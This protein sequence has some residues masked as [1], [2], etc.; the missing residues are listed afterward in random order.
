MTV[1]DI[2]ET[3]KQKVKVVFDDQLTLVLYKGELK[4]Y[5]LKKGA[6]VPEDLPRRIEKEVL[7]KRATK[8]AMNLLVKRD[9]TAKELT[10][11]LLR[12]GYSETAGREALRYVSSYGYV[13]DEDYARRYLE[14]YSDRKTFKVMQLELLRKGIPE[15]IISRARE[16]A[17]TADE[18][19]LLRKL[20]EKKAAALNLSEDKDCQKLLRF[21]LG[22][23]FS[24]SQA[25]EALTELQAENKMKTD[26]W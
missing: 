13:R 2:I 7:Y 5:C 10:D 16:A 9:Y 18:Q 20:A 3:T 21:L 8:Y 14:T 24:Y 22:K 4:Q 19:E 6:E 15:E 26:L 17:E 1:T 11:R 12:A 23:G 25:K